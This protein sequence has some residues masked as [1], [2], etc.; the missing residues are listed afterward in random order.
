MKVYYQGIS[1]RN[2]REIKD[3]YKN[4]MPEVETGVTEIIEF[5]KDSVEAQ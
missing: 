1:L 2:L 3:R 5:R 4:L